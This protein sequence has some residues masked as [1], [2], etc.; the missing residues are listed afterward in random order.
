MN[1]TTGVIGLRNAAAPMQ[2][3]LLT[4]WGRYP[5]V[6]HEHIFRPD[7]DEQIFPILRETKGSLLPFGL[8]RSYG[9]SCLNAGGDLIDCSA[10]NRFLAADF[11]EGWIRCEGGTALGD[12]LEVIVP[13]GWFLQLLPV[14]S[15]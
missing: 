7:W 5:R 14:L 4:S 2:N 3:S 12:I 15:S 13:K 8:G 1:E 6:S 11:H 10:L 9:D